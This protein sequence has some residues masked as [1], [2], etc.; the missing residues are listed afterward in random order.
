MSLLKS[1]LDVGF[2]S[3][4]FEQDL[5]HEH[6]AMVFLYPSVSCQSD[7]ETLH[8]SRQSDQYLDI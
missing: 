2:L 4:L 6:L 7:K 1:H 3:I 5:Y 8:V